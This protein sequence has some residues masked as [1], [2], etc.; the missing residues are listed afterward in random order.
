MIER[1]IQTIKGLSIKALK[2]KEDLF[3]TILNYN[4]TPK[5]NLPAPSVMLMGRRLRTELSINLQLLKPIYPL[6]DVKKQLNDNQEKQKRQ[7]Y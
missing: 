3:L 2:N 4:S 5:Q 1:T 7:I 6:K